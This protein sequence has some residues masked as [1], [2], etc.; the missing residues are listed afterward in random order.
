AFA[1]A[2]AAAGVPAVA[3][4]QAAGALGLTLDLGR[5]LH[6]GDRFYLRWEQAFTLDGE[7][8]GD[9]R[10]LWAELKTKT[11]GTVVLQRFRPRDGDEQL[12]LASGQ[13]TGPA[14]LRMPLDSI[15]ITSG[16]GL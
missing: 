6:D 12:F 4:R 13:G 3:I 8:T 15:K 5:D 10:L 14:R 16:Y 11:R 7:T 2:T 1:D 9:P